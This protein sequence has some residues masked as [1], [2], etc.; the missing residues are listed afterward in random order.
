MI[1][2]EELLEHASETGFRLCSKEGWIS[3]DSSDDTWTNSFSATWDPNDSNKLFVCSQTGQ[4]RIIDISTGSTKDYHVLFRRFSPAYEGTGGD[5]GKPVPNHWDKM[6]LVPNKPGEIIFLLG[7]SKMLLY[8]AVPG[9]LGPYPQEPMLARTTRG[10]S[11]D[12]IYGTPILELCPQTC[13]ITALA[14]SNNGHLLASGDEQGNMK[15]CV[16]VRQID[17]NITSFVNEK[18]SVLK[19]MTRFSDAIFEEYP[20]SKVSIKA[21][22]GPIFSTQWLPVTVPIPS[23]SS[24]P[25]LG[26]FLATGSADRAVRVWKVVCCARTGISVAPAFSLDTVAT[27]VLS[28]HSYLMLGDVQFSNSMG[29]GEQL[30]ND[31]NDVCGGNALLT[32]AS[33]GATITETSNEEKRN[34]YDT[35]HKDKIT[36]QKTP[37]KVAAQIFRAGKLFQHKRSSIY[38][39]CSSSSSI[40]LAAGTNTGCVYLWKFSHNELQA[41]AISNHHLNPLPDD[42]SRLHSLI[43]SSQYPVVQIS[44]SSAADPDVLKSTNGTEIKP[45][46]FLS[47]LC[48]ALYVIFFQVMNIFF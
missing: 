7:I 32:I 16:L 22:G 4:L 26:Y 31:I 3:D 20:N 18:R 14:A 38:I 40:Y 2:E 44:L 5:I 37:K 19:S 17:S 47:G 39:D 24:M 29:A 30:Y 45:H 1:E 36:V 42:G 27:H 10:D 34:L 43:Q 6:V 21:H 13:R 8:T 46:R 48:F 41:H 23:S 15:V 33:E 12:F 28:L 25:S 35:P 11:S 9:H